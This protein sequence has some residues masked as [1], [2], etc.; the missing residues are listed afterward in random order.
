MSNVIARETLRA[1]LLTTPGLPAT[2]LI[3]KE[4]RFFRP[5]VDTKAAWLRENL[6]PFAEKRRN[7]GPSF[8]IRSFGIYMVDVFFAADEGT[9]GVDTLA[10]AIVSQFWPGLQLARSGQTLTI[11]TSSRM[12][13]VQETDWLMV[14]VSISYHFDNIRTNP[15]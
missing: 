14:P 12:G 15:Q 4:G 8:V 13:S 2:N 1:R 10:D 5:P 9:G 11:E 7:I 3:Q 6:K